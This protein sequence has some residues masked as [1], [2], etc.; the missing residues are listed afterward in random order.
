MCAYLV[1]ERPGCGGSRE[2][3]YATRA[4]AVL[5]NISRQQ[6]HNQSEETGKTRT[7]RRST[8][9][10]WDA[11]VCCTPV[12]NLFTCHICELTWSSL[13]AALVRR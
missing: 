13:R 5:G 12:S 3:R 10:E 7:Y 6:G 9:L 2:D 4:V 11:T 8:R 1:V